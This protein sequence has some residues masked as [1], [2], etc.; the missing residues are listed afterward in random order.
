MSEGTMKKFSHYNS[1]FCRYIK[2]E[3]GCKHFHHKENCEI[4]V[5]KDK[6]CPKRHPNICRYLDQCR[7]QSQCSYSHKINEKTKL[8]EIIK[9]ILN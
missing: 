4:T 5:C 9:K 3:Y 6:E 7:F 1:G 8:L 2:K